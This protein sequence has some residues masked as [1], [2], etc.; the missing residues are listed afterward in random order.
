[1]TSRSPFPFH[2]AYFVSELLDAEPAASDAD[3]VLPGAVDVDVE[4]SGEK[5]IEKCPL[6][7]EAKRP[8][9]RLYSAQSKPR[10]QRITI[11]LVLLVLNTHDTQFSHSL[12]HKFRI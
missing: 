2:T 10:H 4:I 5:V 11:S 7:G 3:A 1:M 8:P 9:N 12:S 6:F